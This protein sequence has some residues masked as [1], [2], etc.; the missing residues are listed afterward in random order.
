MLLVCPSF[1]SGGQ[2]AGGAVRREARAAA[3][4]GAGSSGRLALGAVRESAPL[5]LQRGAPVLERGH[6]PRAA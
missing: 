1:G 6:T 3:A 2:G 5:H 4:G